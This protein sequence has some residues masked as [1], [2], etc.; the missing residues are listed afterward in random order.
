MRIPPPASDLC[1]FYSWSLLLNVWVARRSVQ[2]RVCGSRSS[3]NEIINVSL[4]HKLQ[5]RTVNRT[6]GAETADV[7][8]LSSRLE[9]IRFKTKWP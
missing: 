7:C 4:Q 1:S 2:H 9:S 3:A 8:R 6:C 5:K